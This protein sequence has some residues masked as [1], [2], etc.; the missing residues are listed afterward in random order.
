[1][2]QLTILLGIFF[3]LFLSSQVDSVALQTPEG[4]TNKMLEL[5]SG[6]IDAPRDWDEYRNLFLPT[7]QKISVNKNAPPR[8]QVRVMNLEE[9]V[10]NVGPLYKRDGFDEYAIGLTV[11]E[12][13]GIA[14]V[15][16]TFYCKN[17]LGT[18][19]KRGI[20]NYQLVFAD[21]RWWIANTMF[22]NETE[23]SPIPE[24]YLFK[25]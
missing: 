12:Y 13:N 2:K 5:I 23:D 18:Y 4:I 17:L 7:A 9:F 19:E 21:N 14:T 8:R 11:E 25:K 16:Q 20:N 15:F 10:R 24:K 1:M 3:P 22:T 6:E